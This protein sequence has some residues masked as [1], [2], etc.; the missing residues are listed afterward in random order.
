MLYLK[1]RNGYR[2]VLGTKISVM[3]KFIFNFNIFMG[4]KI[5]AFLFIKEKPHFWAAILDFWGRHLGI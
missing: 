2:H 5:N 3:P 4:L 1:N